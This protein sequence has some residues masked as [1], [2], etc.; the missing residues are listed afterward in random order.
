ME[1]EILKSLAFDDTKIFKVIADSYSNHDDC[2]CITNCD[3][4]S[5][6]IGDCDCDC[7][8]DCNEP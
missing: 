1:Q 5:E 4:A 2:D 3:C 7:I 6:G 8:T